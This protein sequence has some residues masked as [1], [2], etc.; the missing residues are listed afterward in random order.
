[1]IRRDEFIQKISE[2]NN[3]NYL[4]RELI[5]LEK[6]VDEQLL[7]DENVIKFINRNTQGGDFN[8][9]SNEELVDSINDTNQIHRHPDVV[10]TTKEAEGIYKVWNDSLTNQDG[11]NLSTKPYI[12]KTL[13][14]DIDSSIEILLPENTNKNVALL[15]KKKY[16]STDLKTEDGGFWSIITRPDTNNISNISEDNNDMV[17]VVYN[18]DL[19]TVRM[20]FKLFK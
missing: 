19:N 12:D 20:I 5:D 14:N 18:K 3:N 2:L 1:M 7:I 4:K 15:L 10:S 11:R 13:H 8:N 17:E 6:Y 9:T 16:L